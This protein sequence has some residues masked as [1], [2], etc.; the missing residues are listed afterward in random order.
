MIRDSEAGE[1]L[2]NEALELVTNEAKRES[3]SRNIAAL[4]IRDAD[5]VIAREILGMDKGN[6]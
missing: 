3:L 6:K 1:K 2:V 5:V 4:G